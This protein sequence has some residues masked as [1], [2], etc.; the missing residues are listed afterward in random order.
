[1]KG[2]SK[3][4]NISKGI[5]IYLRKD[6]PKYYGCLRINGKYYR[7]SL[8]TVDKDQA[9]SLVLKWNEEKTNEISKSL[10]SKKT[11]L[12]DHP[13][14]ITYSLDD[15]YSLDKGRV[16]LTGTQALVR[17]PIIQRKIDTNIGINSAGY[18]SGYTGSP[19]G[20]YDHAL[21]QASDFLKNNHI[22]FQPGINE[23]LAATALHGSQQTTLVEKPKYDG[24]FGIWYGK[25]PG[26][27]RSGDALKHGNYA[28]TSKYGG[29]LALA[30]D[31]HGAKSSTTAHQSDHAFIHFGMPI[32]NPSTV[33][34]YLDFGILGFA[35]SRYSGCW[36]GFKCVTDTV[37]SAASVDIS[38]DRF[39]PI[40]PKDCSI[41]DENIHIQWGFAPAASEPRLYKVRLP[42]AQAFARANSIDKVIFKDKKK[43]AII[44]SGKAYLDVR[45]ALDELG[46]D[47][48]ECKKIGVSLYKV[49]MVWPLED[50]KILD[51]VEGHK[52]VL[53]IEEKRA[54]V[55]DQLTK[56]LYNK[57]N[58]PNIVG[59]NDEN[60]DYLVPSEGELSPSLV[61]LIIAK[62]I[63]NLSLKVDLSEKV[64]KI[65]DFLES[66]NQSP[67]SNLF[68]LPSFCAGCPHNTSTK[69]PEDSFAFGGIGC[70]GMATFMPERH[71]YNLG[72]MGGEG[73]MWTGIA[74]FTETDHIFQNLG[75]GTY[76]HSG[77][78][79]LRSAVASGANVTYKI[80]VNDAIAMTGGQEITGKVRIDDLTWQVHS[81]GAK[82]VVVVTDYPDKYPKNTSFAPGVEVFQRDKLDEV[83]K[84]LREIK[85][86]TVIL[87]DQYCATELRRRRKRG[88][89][90][91]PKKKIFINP[92]V[93]EGCGD[94]GVESNC[95]AIEPLETKFGRKRQIN[96]SA[97]NKDFSCTKG[98]CPS[99]LTITG[100]KLK[101]KS[102]SS[103]KSYDHSRINLP[104]P[105]SPDMDKPFNILITGIGGSGVITLGAILG[106]AAHLEGK[107]SST[108]D[109]AGLA[110]RNGPVTSH[111]RVANSQNELHATRI[112]SGSADLIIGCDIVVTT[113]I[114]AMSK[115][116]P[117]RTNMIINNHVA[118]TSTFASDPDLDLSSARMI[119]GLKD[120]GSEELMHFINASRFSTSLMG[121][122]IGANLFLV[123]YAIQK[124]LF[125]ISLKAIERAIEL[126]GVSIEMNKES[127]YWGR[128]AAI[129]IKKVEQVAYS[130]TDINEDLE[131]LSLKSIIKDRSKFLTSYQDL[132]YANKYNSFLNKIINVDNLISNDRNEFSIAV[133]KNYFKLM[134][135]KDEYEVA[136]LHTGKEIKEYLD[137]KLE[138]DYTIEYSLAPPVF[139]GRNKTTGKYPKRKLPSFTY[140][141]FNVLKYF[142]FLRGTS[143]DIFGLSKHRKIERQLI[144]EYE[145]MITKIL[146]NINNDNYDV[147]I[148][149]ASLPQ[150]IKG[151]DVI[152]ELNI[153]K[154]KIL[155][156]K[157]FNEF[158]GNNINIVNKY[159]IAAG[160]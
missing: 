99:F 83:Q 10:L 78:L 27:D 39:K 156:D 138:G 26:V 148:K 56:Y 64:K 59:K 149:I 5:S 108:L 1:M 98:Y 153:E 90:E 30:G 73:V 52:E 101:Q 34:D 88:L 35:M 11:K 140:Y 142:K 2:A 115:I 13:L 45:Q 44:T 147:A 145:Q 70:H 137:D 4:W 55:E 28:G 9:I 6:T 146:N 152:K 135:Y 159:P 17:L 14:N 24:V 119:K 150:Q 71:T 158:N 21:N 126:N 41:G 75:D 125:P 72:Q 50:Q 111:L 65:E 89:V 48:K 118:P 121:N 93:C 49:G 61:A 63:I 131:E 15:K 37:E 57:K 117:G 122:A 87:Y 25:G 123:G 106:T 40:I 19:L 130:D 92:L 22:V 74:P 128:L 100:G 107:G 32:L 69:V 95:I 12:T 102:K 76:Y 60:G 51:F 81:E 53:V 31:D 33:Q 103:D 3:S 127:I 20:G 84:N 97:C 96:Q 151:Y 62:R 116:S 47:D 46:L 80:L 54:I 68:R 139:G 86:V 157:Y 29:V 85:G 16:F 67:G 43:L 114:E 77:I 82:K 113:G 160:E 18:I 124:G 94:C 132:K 66:I 79:A 8:N 104:T 134:S 154:T 155:E 36:V 141:I 91:E 7:K 133:A 136:R 42:A 109:V 129:D 144:V 143:F 110:Q 23:D 58:R 38:L 112:A 105:L 120:V